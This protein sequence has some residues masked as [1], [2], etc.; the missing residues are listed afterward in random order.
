M[1]NLV[2]KLV[3]SDLKNIAKSHNIT[4]HSKIKSQEI[5]NAISSHIC[6]DCKNHVSVFEMIDEENKSSK[7]KAK[8]LEAVKKY[9]AK[10]SEKYKASHLKAV[11]QN[12]AENIDKYRMSNLKAV[13]KHQAKN[14]DYKASN[15]EAVQKNQAK[16]PEYKASH[17]EAVQKNQAKNPDYKT[18]NLQAVKT[19][20]TKYSN[21]AKKANLESVHKYQKKKATAFP[22]LPPSK[23]LQHTIISNFCKDTSPNKF[24]ESGCAICGKLTPLTEL[25]KLS[26]LNLDLNILIQ[27]EV[28]Q[29]E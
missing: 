1:P 21:K 19:Y 7:A 2:L 10:N 20:Q 27:S 14:P 8:H 15:L 6:K 13:Q 3:I 11:Q 24:I 23:K 26:D 18:S 25:N 5:Q 29:Q 28:T 12:R 17:L 9:Q 16:N 4:V 22:P